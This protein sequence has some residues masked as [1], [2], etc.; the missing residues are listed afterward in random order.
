MT[1]A[2]TDPE[3][4]SLLD[5][6]KRNRSFDFTGYKR[7]TLMRRVQKRMKAVE[8]ES[9][10]AYIDHLEVHPGE[11]AALFNTILINGTSVFRDPDAW[12]TLAADVIPQVAAR[13]PSHPI[14]VW[15]A[16]CASGEET[17]TLVMVLAEALGV[18]AF[19]ERVKVYAT[20]VD[21]EALA[22]ARQ[23]SYDTRDLEA[24]PEA[25]RAKY[26]E[27]MGG[28]FVFR[29]DLRRLVIF[30]RHD[31]VRDPP[32]SHLDLLVSRNALMYF[33]AQVQ[34]RILS[35]FHFALGDGGLLFLGKAEMMRAHGDLFRPV[36]L[37]ARIFGKVA[38]G[39]VRD[40][41]LL[42]APSVGGDGGEKLQRQVRLREAALD[43]H[44]AAQLVVDPRG[45]LVLANARARYL[46]GLASADLG[47]PLRDLTVSYRP[48][49]LRSRIEEVLA[50]RVADTVS[51]VELPLPDGE[52]HV[53]DVHVVPLLGPD[54]GPLGVSVTFVDVTGYQRLQA[55][56][57]QT[58]QELETAFEELQSTNE[59]LET[60]N[61][62]LQSTIEEL[63]TT[64][65]ELQSTNEELET[66]NEELQSTNE[67][68]ET[69]ND[70]LNR[71]TAEVNHASAYMASILASLRVAV[72]VVDRASDIRVWNRKAEDLWGL[73]PEEVEG[74]AFQNLDI[75]LPVERLKGAVRACID[76][77][78]EVEET[79][80]EAVNRRG[81]AI[82]CR[83]TCAPFLGGD[84]EIHG[85][86]LTMEEWTGAAD[87]REGGATG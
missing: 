43:A 72:A 44:N 32:I 30:G 67:E 3:F 59:E 6:L 23:A 29:A 42:M 31:L 47:R 85:A 53:F 65:E 19:R 62:E 46:F 78:S 69:M 8:M 27:P 21:A 34:A 37:R 40:R 76:G 12:R 75:G 16:G 25:L 13:R 2:K 73:R 68:L 38:R 18:D 55:E 61:E 35:R 84:R 66:M 50:S 74:H 26:F 9:Y 15:S 20:D 4:E 58:H 36:D 22:Q 48:V 80:L 49:E 82:R 83:V 14:R 86:V 24:V 10:A 11:F 5:Y 33:N 57:R 63:E 71:R 45:G 1:P 52:L 51:G 39:S 87:G 77:K 17:Y 7:S 60:T 70:E 56:L 28:R 81:R 54:K 79:V 41:L 64:N